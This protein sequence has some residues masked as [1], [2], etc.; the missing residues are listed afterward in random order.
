MLAHERIWFLQRLDPRNSA[1]HLAGLV[2]F[3]APVPIQTL[4]T[5]L[6]QVIQRHLLL[7]SAVAAGDP[8]PTL[9]PAT[10][11]IHE[12]LEDDRDFAAA[13]E[14]RVH[15]PFALEREAPLRVWLHN[16]GNRT[17]LLLVLHHAA[18]DGWSLAVLARDLDSHLQAL[19][20][21]RAPDLPELPWSPADWAAFQRAELGA[22][23]SAPSL[24]YWRSQLQDAPTTLD[25]PSDRPRPAQASHAGQRLTVPI[26]AD[27]WQAAQTRA[28]ALGATPFH[29]FLAAFAELVSRLTLQRDF[30]LGTVTAGRDHPGLHHQIGCFLNLLALRLPLDQEAS[31]SDRIAQARRVS[32]EALE[33][34]R[35]PFAKVLEELQPPRDLSRAPL[36]QV[37]FEWLELPEATDPRAEQAY[38][39][40]ELAG[41]RAKFDFTARVRPGNAPCLEVDYA[42]DLFDEATVASWCRSLQALLEAAVQ[43]P[44]KAPPPAMHAPAV[45][46]TDH[47][48]LRDWTSTAWTAARPGSLANRFEDALRAHGP[49]TAVTWPQGRQTFDELLAAAKA[50][51]NQL[52]G[53]GIG[54]GSLVGV[55]V[56]RGPQLLPA[57]LGTWFAGATYL[58]LEAQD[59]PLRHRQ[60]LESAGASWVLR[61][62]GQ[63]DAWQLEDRANGKALEGQPAYVMCTSGS[64]GQPKAVVIGQAALLHYLDAAA[65]DYLDAAEGGSLLH[66]AMTFDLTVTSLYAP[67]LHGQRVHMAEPGYG[68]EPLL[69]ARDFGPF[70]F[71]KVTPAHLRA[72]EAAET[73]IP[74]ACTWV[75]GG[76]VL[77]TADVRPLLADGA[78]VVNEY[79]PTEATVGCV[80]HEIPPAASADDDAA[81]QP[82]GRPIPGATLT[83]RD[84]QQQLS[85]PGALG[86]LW[87]GGPGL[88]EGYL[89]DPELNNRCFAAAEPDGMRM[90]R[91]GDLARWRCDGTLEFHG[92]R[93]SQVQVLGVRIEPQEIE[94]SLRSL[95]EVV[96]AAVQPVTGPSGLQLGAWVVTDGSSDGATLHQ[97]LQ[98]RLPRALLPRF[99]HVLDA[100]PMTSHGKLD[101]GALQPPRSPGLSALAENFSHGSQTQKFCDLMSEL[102]STDVQADED[103]FALGG[104]SILALQVVARAREWGS[105]VAVRDIFLHRTPAR[106]AMAT[107]VAEAP[108]ASDF[109]PLAAATL[110][111][112]QRQWLERRLAEPGH[113][114]QALLCEVPANLTAEVL[115]RALEQLQTAHPIL[116]ARLVDGP[117]RLLPGIG[118]MVRSRRTEQPVAAACAQANASHEPT[119]GRVFAATCVR[120]GDLRL[121]HLSAHHLVI[122]ALSWSILLRDLDR[123]LQGQDLEPGTPAAAYPHALIEQDFA[124]E[125]ELWRQ[126]LPSQ[127]R[128]WPPTTDHEAGQHRLRWDDPMPWAKAAAQRRASVQELLVAAM[129]AAMSEC[130]GHAQVIDI[131]R[132]GRLDLP[133]GPDLSRAI[134][135]FTAVHPLQLPEAATPAEWLRATKR[136]LRSLP[137]DGLGY[138]AL[139]WLHGCEELVP[140]SPAGLL[141]NHLGTLDPPAGKLLRATDRDPGPLRSS[142]HAALYPLEFDLWF[143]QDVLR[144]RLRRSRGVAPEAAE[145]LLAAFGRQLRAL[146]DVD[147]LECLEPSDYPRATVDQTQLHALATECVPEQL[148]ASSPTQQGMLVHALQDPVSEAYM[149]QLVHVVEGSLRPEAVHTA[150]TELQRRHV[151][152]RAELVWQGLDQPHW[153]TG[154]AVATPFAVRDIQGQ[155]PTEAREF[156]DRFTQA[157]RRAG[158]DLG[159]AP[160][161]RCTQVRMPQGRHALVFTYHHVLMDGWSMPLLLAE[162]NAAYQAACEGQPAQ[163]PPALPYEDYS[164]WLQQQDLGAAQDYW[165]QQL[166][167]FQQPTALGCAD[168]SPAEERAV[169]HEETEHWTTPETARALRNL[170]S[171]CQTTGSTLVQA[172]LATWL[173]RTGTWTN[174]DAGDVLFGVTVAGRPADL[175]AADARIGLFINTIPMRL[176]VDEGASV[177]QLLASVQEQNVAS[178]PWHWTPLTTSQAQSD[179]PLG[180]PLFDVLL[181]YENYPLDAAGQ[182]TPEGLRALETRTNERTSYPLTLVVVPGERWLLRALYAPDR[183][184]HACVARLL[185]Q[186]E[187]LL[188]QFAEAPSAKLSEVS[189]LPDAE[190]RWLGEHE[191]ARTLTPDP[192]ILR[193]VADRVVQSPDA[194]A[195]VSSRHSWSYSE[196]AAHSQAIATE[197]TRRGLRPGELVAVD[198]PRSPEQV[199]ALL[200]IWQAGGAAV[201]LDAEWSPSYTARALELAPCRVVLTAS[202]SRLEHLEVLR[203][204]QLTAPSEGSWSQARDVDDSELAACLFTSGSSGEPKAVELL[205]GGLRNYSQAARNEFGIDREDRVLQFASLT[206]DTAFEEILPTLASGATLVL[207]DDDLS[208]ATLLAQ[209]ARHAISVLDFPTAFFHVFAAHLEARDARLPASVRLC[210]LGGEVAQPRPV[211]DFLDRHPALRLINSYGPTEASIVSTW[212]DVRARDGRAGRALPIGVPVP[213]TT[214]SVRDP[215]GR[216][217]PVGTVG[218]LWLAGHGLA[219]GYRDDPEATRLRFVDHPERGGRR[220]FRTGDLVRWREDGQLS[221]CGRVDRQRK[222][223]G[224]RVQPDA[225]ENALASHPDVRQ[226]AVLADELADGSVAGMLAFVVPT[227]EANLDSARLKD[228]AHQRLSGAAIPCRIVPMAELPRTVHGKVDHQRL[229]ALVPAQPEPPPA[230]DLPDVPAQVQAAFAAVLRCDVPPDGDFF[231]HGGN[232]LAAIRLI[233]VLHERAALPLSLAQLF[234]LR[235]PRAV[236]AHAAATGEGAPNLLAEGPLPAPERIAQDLVLDPRLTFSGRAGRETPPRRWLVTGATGYLGRRVVDQLLRRPGHEV[237]V[238]ARDPQATIAA[239]ARLVVGA[240]DQ[241]HLG[242]DQPTWRRLVEEVEG[243]VHVAANTQVWQPYEALRGDNVEGTRHVI[244]FCAAADAALHHVSTVGIFTDPALAAGEPISESFDV[245][246]LHAV[247]GGY[248]QSKWVAERLVQ[249]AASRGLAAAIYRPGRLVAG[250][251]GG[252]PQSDLGLGLF[253]LGLELGVVPEVDL[254]IDLTPV[255]W[256]ASALVQLAMRPLQEPEQGA[257]PPTW[258][259]LQDPPT[260]MTALWELLDE[261]GV[262]LRRIPLA[263]WFEVAK[264]HVESLPEHPARGL[265]DLLGPA[266]A[267]GD[268][269]PAG[270]AV[271]APQTY[272][273]L[274]HSQLPPAALTARG[275]AAVLH[276]R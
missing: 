97:A 127:D 239:E 147:P 226:V 213:G 187:H 88:A 216:L 56:P 129:F 123:A 176:R 233:D 110:L 270:P 134:G 275:L 263:A 18:A 202:A 99:V 66:T 12:A 210:I 271:V 90:Y 106:L 161:W 73:A 65:V 105:Q 94:Q 84:A 113:D 171:A 112:I 33:H 163:L 148:F 273:A 70:A 250:L 159:R 104:D 67:L 224:Q 238:L 155:S 274:E 20:K 266:I 169:A 160:L 149:E 252:P 156:L 24:R 19:L 218:E 153:R 76:D 195:I 220:W 194:P 83:I 251:D 100:M 227:A 203:I 62:D 243:V 170:A 68:I 259:L 186:L 201:P 55:V 193:Q 81:P 126:M 26:D 265:L 133:G 37:T 42:T 118:P 121:L 49:A 58:P 108:T 86:E 139:R 14:A 27:L 107:E 30:V 164:A 150:L 103:F 180:K 162:L 128:V 165:R 93:D 36:V 244:E 264:T 222:L 92:R 231:E 23:A 208:P 87:V 44:A 248:P 25:L 232:S 43:T 221:F 189:V 78:R 262:P 182:A 131:E 154:R 257:T 219:R 256:A 183:L 143:Q 130:A 151:L 191:T 32:T 197:L 135:W 177:G 115:D 192:S 174:P 85:P 212:C 132:H 91:T 6:E 242:L 125:L 206:F 145:Q 199:A 175:P 158:V 269:E 152:L 258:H 217:V 13:L 181:V 4:R 140:R 77:R 268:L 9:R 16:H 75:V 57:Y 48:R 247:Q 119:A 188:Q 240:V 237:T 11:Q 142:T 137:N 46:P 235:T 69:A 54:P 2:S 101:R 1:Y 141:L 167:G 102:L 272:R 47:D 53:V 184:P 10:P 254:A 229:L 96:D 245:G 146:W 230:T 34:A 234:R 253:T 124:G 215:R 228:H 136:V 255:D 207:R 45:H 15:E 209:C 98:E 5:A 63:T 179:A 190:V 59:P 168:L 116:R 71:L 111:P 82:I 40:R 7:R 61:W 35:I 38:R 64:T 89:G 246:Q 196:L 200:G 72:L 17:Q 79:G 225:I 267:G 60:L 31:W 74:R 117:A 29:V 276:G 114:V 52:R 198:L 205:H 214:L 80:R 8:T 241:D 261:V 3:D 157:D 204:D 138:G 173:A 122:D 185:E 120:E 236:A 109:S 95:P 211:A 28:Q 51:A 166:A 50:V 223:H 41:D 22:D 172:A 260:E 39:I 144:G 21:E 249:A 178:M